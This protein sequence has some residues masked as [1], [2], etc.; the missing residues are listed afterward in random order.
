ML[1]E[2]Q[3]VILLPRSE[4]YGVGNWQKQKERRSPNSERCFAK[5]KFDGTGD[6]KKRQPYL[7][8]SA[9]LLLHRQVL[10]DME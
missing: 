3:G 10:L 2:K 6:G 4:T 8:L 7:F 1:M 5:N 9:L